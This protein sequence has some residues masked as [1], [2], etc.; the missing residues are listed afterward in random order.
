MT[1][2]NA[3]VG[4]TTVGSLVTNISTTGASTVNI[5]NTGTSVTAGSIVNIGTGATGINIGNSATLLNLTGKVR[6]SSNPVISYYFTTGQ[7][8][9]ISDRTNTVVKYPNADTRNSTGTGITYNVSTGVYTNSNSYSVVIVVSASLYY[10]GNAV[11]V[12]A[13]SIIFGTTTAAFCQTNSG[14]NAIS[15]NESASFI[16]N[17]SETFY[18]NTY[19]DSGSNLTIPA[20]SISRVNVLV[21]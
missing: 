5:G 19:Q 20:D 3:T 2:G 13:L 9:N 12:R 17:S 6:L 18:V 16:V 4:T 10:P 7:T 8:Q 15:L 1:L 14:A 21:L 11:G